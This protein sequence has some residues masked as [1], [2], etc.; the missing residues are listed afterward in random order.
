MALTGLTL[1]SLKSSIEGVSLYET[2]NYE[3]L[4]LLISST[5]LKKTFNNPVS[6][7][8]YENE[9]QQL[10]CYKKIIKEGKAQITY[11]KTKGMKYGRVMPPKALGLC[12]IRREIRHT[13]TRGTY[14]DIDIDNC[15]PVLLSQI[16]KNN[17]I[18]CPMLDRYITERNEMLQRVMTD[19][20]VNRDTAKRLFIRLFYFGSFDEWVKDENI[21]PELKAF[22]FLTNFKNELSHIGDII[23]AANPKLTTIINDKKL[24]ESPNNEVK[25][26][27]VKS[28]LCSTYLQ[29][30]E[31]QLLD[32]IFKYS[33][34]KRYITDDAILC[35][36]GLMMPKENYKPE[37]LKEFEN[38]I[39]EKT[40]FKVNFST[41]D[42][43]QGFSEETIK[44]SQE[45]EEE[46]PYSLEKKSF[47]K[48]NFK[49]M[50]PITY[51]TESADGLIIRKK[52][53]FMDAY[54]NR[55][56]VDM[57]ENAKGDMK[58]KEVS[59]TKK[60]FEDPNI[61][62][63]DR[64]DFLPCQNAPKNIYNT[65]KGFVGSTKKINDV[66]IMETLMMKH[67]RHLCNHDDKV[68]DYVLD[69]FS[70][71]VQHPYKLTRTAL[72]FKTIQGCGKDTLFDYIGNKIL[73][74]N[75]YVVLTDVKKI[76]GNFNSTLENKILVV[77]NESKSK[78]AFEFDDAIKD[79]ITRKENIIEPK[80]KD[81][82]KN[83]N[84]IFY[85]FLT[86]NKNA[87][88]VE[89]NDRR[90][91]AIDGD[92]TIAND[93]DYFTALNKEIDDGFIDGAF[94]H[95]LN[96][97]DISK[98]NFTKDRPI[99]SLYETLKE[100]N[101]PI[102]GRFLCEFVDEYSSNEIEKIGSSELFNKFN[103]WKEKNKFN[104][105]ECTST[106]FGIDL[107]DYEHITKKKRNGGVMMYSINIVKLKEFL[108]KKKYYE[109]L[110]YET[111]FIDDEP[112]TKNI[113]IKYDLDQGIDV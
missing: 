112:I 56:I 65:F 104:S 55:R 12:A 106:K 111:D 97:R 7:V 63:Y 89:E 90:F 41:K 31:C 32:I 71:M 85:V 84:N 14:I 107:K 18:E 60:W 45:A 29:E 39:F 6:T 34:E 113:K 15:H 22:S 103:H 110:E 79:A 16:L 38:I 78:T 36:D 66:N 109:E 92:N 47:E 59:F 11:K 86:N 105:Y 19:Y 76:F 2:V 10:Q 87:I 53:E 1:E 28:S 102:L 35:Y 98:V 64:I 48:I 13:L 5:L 54:E 101:I 77:V 68:V 51:A 58:L 93:N 46:N 43:D 61:R 17:N 96:T 99:T 9:K 50:Q 52:N 95:F 23:M 70:N 40:G 30:I 83:T 33:K 69:C 62:T 94:Y 57:A 20:N 42:L 74:S 49:I 25:I 82:Y 4:C 81:A 37:I 73:G 108:I 75:Y 44:D 88:K 67:I 24:K 3:L 26:W 80:G 91:C 21:A 27:K 8:Y 100:H 72:L